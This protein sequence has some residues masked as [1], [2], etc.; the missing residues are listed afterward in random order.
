M[1]V[2][3]QAKDS[4]LKSAHSE[5]WQNWDV[6]QLVDVEFDF[7]LHLCIFHAEIIKELLRGSF[8]SL[9]MSIMH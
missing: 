6:H 3:L 5:H 2:F 4:F 7:N 8:K 9:R 1:S